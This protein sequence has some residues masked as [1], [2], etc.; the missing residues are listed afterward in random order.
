MQAAGVQLVGIFS[1]MADLF[2][3]WRNEK[4]TAEQVIA[5]MNRYT[6]EYSMSARQFNA[7]KIGKV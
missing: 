7:A 4:P 6:P 5:W 2:R 3:D 1:I